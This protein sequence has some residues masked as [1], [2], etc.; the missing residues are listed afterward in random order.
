MGLGALN[1]LFTSDINC[2]IKL[3]AFVEEK[4]PR[5]DQSL[6]PEW[7]KFDLFTVYTNQSDMLPDR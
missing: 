1:F 7:M 2:L 6:K 5:T 3:A 4:A